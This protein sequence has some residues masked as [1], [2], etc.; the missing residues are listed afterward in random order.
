MTET[1]LS[2]EWCE[3]EVDAAVLTRSGFSCT[4]RAEQQR[5]GEENAVT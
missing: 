3:P 5:Q 2:Y 4:D 1:I